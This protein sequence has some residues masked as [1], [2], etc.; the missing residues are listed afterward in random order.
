MLLKRWRS[1][2]STRSCRNTEICC[3]LLSRRPRPTGNVCFCAT[4]L[5]LS[6]RTRSST[7][8]NWE[9]TLCRKWKA[10][11]DK[12]AKDL[13]FVTTHHLV[14][15]TGGSNEEYPDSERSENG[16]RRTSRHAPSRTTHD[17]HNSPLCTARLIACLKN[18]R[19]KK[20]SP[21]FKWQIWQLAKVGVAR[22]QGQFVLLSD[23]R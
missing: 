18:L 1:S 12:D 17:D 13:L 9:N 21:R 3:C 7:D 2:V 20:K 15:I 19:C 10:R 8:L 6:W 16:V 23:R 5:R 22:D 11:G 14:W 4:V